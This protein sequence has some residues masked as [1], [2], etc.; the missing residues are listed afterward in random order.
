MRVTRSKRWVARHK[1]RFQGVSE[2]EADS[3]GTP[4]SPSRATRACGPVAFDCPRTRA[5]ESLDHCVR[6]PFFVDFRPVPE[7]RLVVLTCQ[8]SDTDPILRS[9]DRRRSWPTVDADAP[10]REARRLALVHEAPL[11]L[12]KDQDEALGVVYREQLEAS[13]EQVAIR[14]NDYPWSLSTRATLGDAVE[15]LRVTRAPALLVL[16]PDGELVGVVS[17]AYLEHLGVP[18]PLLRG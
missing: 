8:C 15:A 9:A 11:V 17:P 14:V 16:A 5:A 2:T 7:R 10:L 4:I 1:E 18:A 3:P 13:D 12:V 6:C